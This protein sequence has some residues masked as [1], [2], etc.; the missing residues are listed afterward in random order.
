MTVVP[1][2]PPAFH[3]MAKPRGAI[4]NLD[5]A[6]CF[7]LRK[8][9]LYKGASFRMSDETLE[10]YTRQYIESQRIPEVQFAW[11]GGE[12]TLMGLDFFR[13]AV[14]LQKKYHKPGMR[15]ANAL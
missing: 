3:V 9:D 2:S 13:R 4:C 15:I 5:C 8:E 12:P 10:S 1:H 6:Y 14:T 11:Q 7:Y